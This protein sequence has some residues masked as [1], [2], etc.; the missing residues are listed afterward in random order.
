MFKAMRHQREAVPLMIEGDFFA[1]WDP[2]TGKTY[3]ALAAASFLD[4]K[5]S[6]FIVP[7]HLREQWA[8]QAAVHTPWRKT[9]VLDKLNEKIPDR[10]FEKADNVIVSYEY[11]AHLPRWKQLRKEQWAAIAIDEA[12]YLMNLEANRTRALLGAKPLTDTNG[13][14]HAAEC[15]WFLTGTPFTFP[16][17]IYPILAAKFPSALKRPSKNGSGLMTAREWEN[18]YCIVKP[19]KSGFGEKVVGA[20]NIP[21]L[22]RR[23][24]DVIDKVR[25]EDA[26][27]MK[28][29]TVDTIP[30]KGTLSK[31]TRGLDPFLVNQYEALTQTLMDPD[32]PD[33]EKL[34]MLEESGEVMAQLRHT[35]AV[36]KI[37]P[38]IEIVK[39]ELAS[40]VKK[41]LIFG[42]HREPL[43]ALAK[44][45]DAPL[46]RGGMTPKAKR[47]AKDEFLYDDT[48]YLIG[49]I[50]A[51]GTGTDGLQDVCHRS[52][53][54]E[55][56]WAFRDNKQCWHRTYRKGQKLPCHSSFITLLGSI[57]E[58][59]ASVLK[60]NAKIVSQVLD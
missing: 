28:G 13:L 17:Q 51:I 31:L 55:P 41:V 18:E 58:Y 33:A 10:V 5:A 42:W 39:N 11:A 6:L 20:K 43:K 54:M 2:G 38:T 22:R 47:D 37:K 24:S 21:A 36:V 46:I 12:H 15:V 56:S 49:Q 26:A 40:G 3:P 34:A 48:P 14:V 1:V 8:E 19:D 25:L 44:E 4:H 30:I 50:S 52:I 60:R 23:L 35:I 27:D 16:N 7:A 57:D 9:V 53:F 59:V 45:L 29:L 32:I